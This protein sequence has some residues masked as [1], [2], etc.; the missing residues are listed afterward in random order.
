MDL[1]II[2]VSWNTREL[3]DDCLKSVRVNLP[4]VSAE[5][6]VV[7][8]ASTDGSQGL[9]RDRYSETHLI[10][11]SDNVGFARANNQAIPQAQGRYVLLLNSDTVVPEGALVA[12]VEAMDAHSD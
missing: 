11:N 3:L 7:D 4:S 9:V 12:L 6:W 5:V 10:A 2:I 8:N 1:S